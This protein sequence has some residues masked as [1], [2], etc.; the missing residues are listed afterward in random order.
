MLTLHTPRR[1]TPSHVQ[2]RDEQQPGAAAQQPGGSAILSHAATQVT[3]HD[4]SDDAEPTL[5]T[6]RSQSEPSL[7][8]ADS[9]SGLVD[10][11]LADPSQAGILQQAASHC[12]NQLQRPEGL[13]GSA[14]RQE[15]VPRRLAHA[16][17]SGR[18]RSGWAGV[19]KAAMQERPHKLQTWFGVDTFI[20]MIPASYSRRVL[21]EQVKAAS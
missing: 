8:D 3:I 6:Q 1:T 10:L 20:T 5:H 21:N 19:P 2:P 7:L 15:N 12:G 11:R 13:E 16:V 18:R 17:S 9:S 4:S 14:D